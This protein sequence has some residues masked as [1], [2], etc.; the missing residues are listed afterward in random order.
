MKSK[1][2][3][4]ISGIFKGIG[5]ACFTTMVYLLSCS[6]TPANKENEP[7]VKEFE[8]DVG[9]DVEN[10]LIY[11]TSLKKPTV[12]RCF[13]VLKVIQLDLKY[14][15]NLST[16]EKKALVYHE[17]G[18]CVRNIFVHAK[19]GTFCGDSIMVPAMMNKWC[20]ETRW[21]TYIK[22]LRKRCK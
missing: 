15:N 22:D 20:Y 7:F 8:K 21:K 14:Y 9:V 19:E 16:I 3:Q 11:F 18:H 1:L 10:V 5:L 17:L 2:K 12:G 6:G 13:P 4:V